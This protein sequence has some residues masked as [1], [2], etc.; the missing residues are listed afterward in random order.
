MPEK[1]FMQNPLDYV[2][3]HGT[4]MGMAEMDR[5]PLPFNAASARLDAH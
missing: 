4:R 5:D 1:V 3:A 2:I